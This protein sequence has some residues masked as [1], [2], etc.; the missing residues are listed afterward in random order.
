M[1]LFSKFKAKQKVQPD[2]AAQTN[3]AAIPKT[4]TA[5]AQIQEGEP[6]VY[7]KDY[8][9]HELFQ[10]EIKLPNILVTIRPHIMGIQ[11]IVKAHLAAIDEYNGQKEKLTAEEGQD[12][13]LPQNILP[14]SMDATVQI[15]SSPDRMAGFL[16]CLPPIGDGRDVD[17]KSLS[18]AIESY[19]I[20]YGIDERTLAKIAARRY[21]YRIF[22]IACGTPP[23]KG[24]DGRIIECFARSPE[25]HLDEDEQGKVDFKNLGLFQ[26]VAKGDVLCEL[27]QPTDG[28]DGH[29]IMGGPVPAVPGSMPAIPQGKNCSVNSNKTAMI[30]DIDG[31][32]SFSKNVFR[33]EAQLT[34]P[35][36]V[37]NS[38][39]NISFTGDVLI[40]GDVLRGFKVKADGNIII[41]GMAEGAILTAGEDI[42]IRKGINGGGI[43]TLTAGGDV[44]SHFLEQTSVSASGHVI[45]ETIINCQI[46]SG[47]NI[48]ALSGKG[49]ILGGSL[50][51]RLCVE[52]HRIG[53]LSNAKTNIKIGYSTQKEDNQ[54]GLKHLNAELEN[55]KNTLD[56]LSK[57]LKIW[58]SLPAI[59]PDKAE[60]HST[61]K[62]QKLL[63]ENL[64]KEQ[65]VKLDMAKGSM[66][67]DYSQC[68]VCSDIIY[69]IT[70]ISL[71]SSKVCIKDA[72]SRCNV[73]FCKD[74]L[75]IGTY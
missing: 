22:L 43:G 40:Q 14:P 44:Y 59:P 62:E 8:L 50:S 13:L 73:Y 6:P 46:I 9:L 70:E 66:K 61:L 60:L 57:N 36:N 29:D 16:Y 34:V 56:I 58:E 10:G 68:R 2:T 54:A 52:A 31:S 64:I 18:I 65:Q 69:G 48:L 19:G 35:G 11:E 32:L 63:Y 42:D 30:A 37:D 25:M 7:S 71:D 17:I 45:A 12:G 20:V 38:T 49:I 24:K 1:S 5:N 39:G 55:S 28:R 74:E 67:I 27:I 4:D 15:F 21:Y 41:L 3:E 75:I 72:T 51:A 26:N 53:S 33:V 47:G 23:E